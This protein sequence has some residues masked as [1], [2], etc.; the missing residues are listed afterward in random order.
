VTSVR[1]KSSGSSSSIEPS[2]LFVLPHALANKVAKRT[3]EEF[4]M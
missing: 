1:M 3:V 4:F 2:R